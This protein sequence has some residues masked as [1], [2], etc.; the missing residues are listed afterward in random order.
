MARGIELDV[1]ER[2]EIAG[3][4]QFDSYFLLVERNEHEGTL[5][6]AKTMDRSLTS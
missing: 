5:T 3:T 6:K 2:S 1:M 4:N